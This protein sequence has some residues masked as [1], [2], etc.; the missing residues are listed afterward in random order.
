VYLTDFQSVPPVWDAIKDTIWPW[1]DNQL[2]EDIVFGDEE[3]KERQP[4][5]EL[6]VDEIESK[7]GILS[8]S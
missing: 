2:R 6:M 5:W 4:W 7:I 3:L 8:L 1:I